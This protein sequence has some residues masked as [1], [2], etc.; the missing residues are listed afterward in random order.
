MLK[1]ILAV[2]LISVLTISAEGHGEKCPLDYICFALDQSGSISIQEYFTIQI[3]TTKAALI[4]DRV[5]P[6]YFAIGFSDYF[7]VVSPPTLNVTLF[8]SN[9]NDPVDPYGTTNMYAA[10]MKCYDYLESKHGNRVIAILSDGKD[11]GEP[12]AKE[13]ADSK[14]G[15]G[16]EIVTVG[17]GPNPNAK[18]LKSLSSSSDFYI[19]GS[20]STTY[21]AK[22][23]GQK[24]CKAA[25]GQPDVCALAYEACDFMFQGQPTV[26]TYF[27]GGKADTAFT[28]KIVSRFGPRIGIV[29]MNDIVPEFINKDGTYSPITYFGNPRFTPTHFKPYAIKGMQYSSGV[30][31]Q[32]FTG[33]QL[34]IARR[35]LCIRVYFSHYQT[36]SGEGSKSRVVNNVNVE[37][38]DN[39]CVVFKTS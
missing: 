37:K 12:P 5:K 30:G 3:I 2:T 24:V 4:L 26:P 14:R 11:K 9:V 33:N 32:T 1:A 39:K 18:L 29:N 38:R 23:L 34:S 35:R 20:S 13:L 22:R 6:S 19:P 15:N 25:L 17:I 21:V 36:L 27:V 28:N 31:H 8:N 16:I 10:L 7:N